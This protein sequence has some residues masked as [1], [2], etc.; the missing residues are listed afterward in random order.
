MQS[1]FFIASLISTLCVAS[2]KPT[3]EQRLS[4]RYEKERDEAGTL[5]DEQTATHD[6][7]DQAERANDVCQFVP[8][9][10]A[11]ANHREQKIDWEKFRERFP[12]PAKYDPKQL[13]LESHLKRL[14]MFVLRNQGELY[15]ATTNFDGKA[16]RVIK[17]K[18]LDLQWYQ[19]AKFIRSK[20]F[21]QSMQPKRWYFTPFAKEHENTIRPDASNVEA[22]IGRKIHPDEIVY[23]NCQNTQIMRMS[24]QANH[25]LINNYTLEQ[26][27]FMASLASKEIPDDSN[28]IQL[29]REEQQI[30]D[31]LNNETR[32]RLENNYAWI[33]FNNVYVP[34]SLDDRIEQLSNSFWNCFSRLWSK[35][36]FQ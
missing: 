21:Y 36:K 2:Q 16:M 33:N 30:Y 9:S 20:H 12:A 28:N 3:R 4:S 24:N 23:L 34:A 8:V 26:L 27:E 29:T 10:K 15:P 1:Y 13:I 17:R 14:R 22:I 11:F 25:K 7:K 18:I 31:E 19:T 6:A 35:K 5:V 32:T